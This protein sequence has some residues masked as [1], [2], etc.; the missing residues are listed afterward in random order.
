M[1]DFAV[2][3]LPLIKKGIFTATTIF[4]SA[5]LGHLPTTLLLRFSGHDV[6]DKS[7]R[8]IGFVER[9]LITLFVLLGLTAQTTFLF[10]TKTAIMAF[11]IPQNDHQKQKKNAEYMLIGTMV[12]FICALFIGHLGKEVWSIIR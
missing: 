9:A 3:T 4:L 2:A 12:S 6:H 11:R 5:G 10:A 1:C 8:W 7:G